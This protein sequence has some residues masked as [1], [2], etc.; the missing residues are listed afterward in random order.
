MCNF[1]GIWIWIWIQGGKLPFHS[2]PS[3]SLKNSRNAG[4]SFRDD[5]SFVCCFDVP[6]STT[7][8]RL[9]A[10]WGADLEMQIWARR[11]SSC[12]KPFRILTPSLEDK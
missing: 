6:F 5:N 12:R 11:P 10:S 3:C 8:L 9:S 2:N 4:S 7:E 1:F